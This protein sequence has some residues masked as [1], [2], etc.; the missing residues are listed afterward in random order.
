MQDKLLKN[1]RVAIS[2]VEK[3]GGKDL[4][5]NTPLHLACQYGLLDEVKKYLK[6]GS[7]VDPR[8]NFNKTPLHLACF[9]KNF[10]VAKLLVENNAD[11]DHQ[12]DFGNSP[13]HVCAAVFAND[14]GRF[15]IKENAKLNIR[16]I[17]GCTELHQCAVVN[18]YELAKDFL[19]K[20]FVDA[21]DKFYNTPLCVACNCGSV[22]TALLLTQH[23]ANIRHKNMYGFSPI[24][25]IDEL[26]QER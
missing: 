7:E 15:L 13:I 3:N 14:I 10:E 17:Y 22:E 6:E 9:A 8:N 4:I 19:P 20:I 2:E 12:D 26:M 1:F 11:I 16:D 21:V 18:N 25:I 23:G 24:D 5:G